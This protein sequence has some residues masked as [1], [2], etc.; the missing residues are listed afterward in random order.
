[1]V[2][3]GSSNKSENHLSE[4][5][6]NVKSRINIVEVIG[7]YVKLVKNGHHYEGQCPFH[8]KGVKKPLRVNPYSCGF[9]CMS[10]GCGGGDVFDFVAKARN[11]TR[12]EAIRLLARKAGIQEPPIEEIDDKAE[13]ISY[14][15]L[16]T[17]QQCPLRYKYRYIKGIRDEHSTFY[18]TVGRAVHAA[19]A[20][21]FRSGNM[22]ERTCDDLLHCLHKHWSSY[23]FS[24]KEEE[25]QWLVRS[26]EMLTE[27]YRT[28][29][30]VVQPVLVEADFRCQVKGLALAGRLDRIDRLSDES[31]MVVDYKV[32]PDEI[33]VPREEDDIQLAVYYYGATRS[34]GLPVS[35]LSFEYLMARKTITLSVN[36][37]EME[38]KLH[39]LEELV[40]VLKATTRFMPSRNKFCVDCV[41]R[42]QCTLFNEHYGA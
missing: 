12:I 27:Y 11:I 2:K 9:I 19:L 23:G 1:M 14:S 16:K 4:F 22:M 10:A 37:A 28:H 31:Y 36:E 29:D 5:E 40:K 33:D 24:S 3:Q 7:E 18:L 34:L 15:M 21:F 13:G 35:K 17:F 32:G 38:S 30:C 8:E 20:S 6:T 26:E 42:P 41:V 39:R 25:N